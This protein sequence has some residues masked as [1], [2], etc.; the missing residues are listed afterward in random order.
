MRVLKTSLLNP[1]CLAL[2]LLVP[3]ASPVLAQKDKTSPSYKT[4][5]ELYRGN[6]VKVVYPVVMPPYTFA[7]EKGEAQGLAIDL[8]RLWSKKTGIPIQFKSALWP[9]GIEMMREGKADIHAALG[10]VEYTFL[11]SV[12][13]WHCGSSLERG[14]LHDFWRYIKRFDVGFN[15]HTR[16]S[17]CL[18]SRPCMAEGY[19]QTGD[20]II[21]L[22]VLGQK[23]S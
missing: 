18:G 19:L 2:F 7:D 1:L 9:E 16:H 15:D 11:W 14:I 23:V 22:S 4:G 3:I 8:L 20:S 6:P 5:S 13:I 17:G 12:R 21:D 10:S